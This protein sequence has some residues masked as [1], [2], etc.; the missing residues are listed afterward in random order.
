[1]CPSVLSISLLLKFFN[2]CKNLFSMFLCFGSRE[3]V[4]DFSFGINKEGSSMQTH[5]CLSIVLFLSP[6]SI[7]VDD[8]VFGICNKWEGKAVL[9][10]KF[11][12]TRIL[13]RG[14]ADNRNPVLRELIHIALQVTGL[15][16]APRSIVF[17]VKIDGYITSEV[18]R[19][20]DF[21]SREGFGLECR[22]FCARF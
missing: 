22:C 7:F 3:N 5:V 15:I 12:V 10:S 1:M 17:G 2:L 19:K 16:C 6:D 14:Y 11:F 20:F 4:D 9:I 13:I 21:F 18:V 8:F